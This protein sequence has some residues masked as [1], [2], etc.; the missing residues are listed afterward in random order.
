M[1]LKK[2]SCLL[3]TKLP[4]GFSVDPSLLHKMRLFDREGSIHNVSSSPAGRIFLKWN[5][6]TIDFIPLITTPQPLH[7]KLTF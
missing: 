6:A 3:E 4:V 7:G 2:I 5:L 1:V